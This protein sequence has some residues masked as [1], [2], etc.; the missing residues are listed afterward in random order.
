M[1]QLVNG[2]WSYDTAFMWLLPTAHLL[3]THLNKPPPSVIV[4]YGIGHIGECHIARHQY[5]LLLEIVRLCKPRATY[6]YD[7][8][9]LEDEK[10]AIKECGCQIILENEV[11]YYSPSIAE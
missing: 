10:T 6:V 5:C 4:C 7:P 8:V 1:I 9:L 2:T 3:T 11:C